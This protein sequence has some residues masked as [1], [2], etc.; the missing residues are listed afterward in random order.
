M[1]QGP[2][3]GD[4][5]TNEVGTNETTISVT[6]PTGLANNDLV[7]CAVVTDDLATISS[8]NSLTKL[9]QEDASGA[10]TLAVFYRVVSSAVSEPSSYTFTWSGGQKCCAAAWRVSNV[11]TVNP[12]NAWTDTEGTSEFPSVLS[13]TTTVQDCAVIYLCG[14]DGDRDAGAQPPANS[15]GKYALDS[16]GG[17]ELCTHLGAHLTTNH[18]TIGATG[19]RNFQISASDQYVTFTLAIAPYPEPIVNVEGF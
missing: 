13:V 19:N 11:D 10:V 15:T 7:I 14:A 3:I 9:G 8:S 1:A 12:I 2:V 5:N 16:G 4:V 6:K 17:S 18:P